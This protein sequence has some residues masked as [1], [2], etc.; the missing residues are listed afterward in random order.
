M[1]LETE[2]ALIIHVIRQLLCFA[3][4]GEFV[5]C[6]GFQTKLVSSF[7]RWTLASR[8]T[9]AVTSEYVH[10]LLFPKARRLLLGGGTNER[11]GNK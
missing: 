2:I 11:Q 1:H 3:V 9:L 4:I 10:L 6:D 7:T 8:D 5:L